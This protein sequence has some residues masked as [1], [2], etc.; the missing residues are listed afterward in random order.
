MCGPLL[1]AVNAA[2][3][4]DPGGVPHNIAYHG[5]RIATYCVLGAISGLIRAAIAFAGF[6][7]WISIAAGSLI[8]LGVLTHPRGPGRHRRKSCGDGQDEVWTADPGPDSPAPPFCWA[9]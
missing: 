8:L 1:L 6:Q 3:R 5:G 9:G 2:R 4:Q 7:R